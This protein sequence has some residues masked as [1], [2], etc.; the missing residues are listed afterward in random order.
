MP[1]DNTY[2][3][4]PNQNNLQPQTPSISEIAQAN[5]PLNTGNGNVE[6]VEETQATAPMPAPE[7]APVPEAAPMPNNQPHEIEIQPLTHPQETVASEPVVQAQPEIQVALQ[8]EA[9][10]TTQSEVSVTP[11]PEAPAAPQ[12]EPQMTPFAP[13]EATSGNQPQPTPQT[14]ITET[15]PQESRVKSYIIASVTIVAL[16]A[17]GFVGYKFL[18]PANDSDIDENTTETV[19]LTNSLSSESTTIEEETTI[20]ETPEA[21]ES[22]EIAEPVDKLEELDA[23]VSELKDIYSPEAEVSPEATLTEV[24]DKEAPAVST[25]GEGGVER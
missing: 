13:A 21:G 9:P 3:V 5:D 1:Q 17:V 4:N 25:N 20:T 18:F 10:V 11:Q 19:E 24:S 12:V 6:I 7:A 8:P 23:V 22:A 16:S 15:T 14:P 2:N